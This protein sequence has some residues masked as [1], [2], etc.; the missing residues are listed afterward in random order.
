MLCP[1]RRARSATFCQITAQTGRRHSAI[2]E[3]IQDGPA[4]RSRRMPH[5]EVPHR[6]QSRRRVL[7]A[8]TS[9][10]AR[11]AHST[12]GMREGGRTKFGVAIP[13][14]DS[15]YSPMTLP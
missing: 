7:H 2:A 11:A 13:R 15:L 5:R 9:V 14:H 10:H 12:A 8:Q 6:G 4:G 1:F 3:E